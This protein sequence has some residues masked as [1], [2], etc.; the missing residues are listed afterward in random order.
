MTLCIHVH[1]HDSL[2]GEMREEHGKAPRRTALLPG[3]MT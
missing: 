2:F 3:A 1:C